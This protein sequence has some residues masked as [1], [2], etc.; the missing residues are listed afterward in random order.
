[1]DTV[2]EGEVKVSQG[3]DKVSHGNVKVNQQLCGQCL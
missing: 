3:E 1:M 2:V